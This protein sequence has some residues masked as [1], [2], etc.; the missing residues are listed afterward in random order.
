MGNYRKWVV[1]RITVN[2]SIKEAEKLK[3]YCSYTGRPATDVIR[4]QIRTLPL[5]SN[6]SPS[7][8]LMKTDYSKWSVKRM[9]VSLTA[10]EAEKLEK[11][12]AYTGRTAIDVVRE[13]IRNI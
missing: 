10:T 5:V 7:R 9:T 8:V 3:T 12:C 11:Y 6:F 1:K 4:E 2:L 13:L